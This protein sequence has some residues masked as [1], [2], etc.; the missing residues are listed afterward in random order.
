MAYRMACMSG[1]TNEAEDKITQ[2]LVTTIV[3]G[4]EAT[5]QYLT[6]QCNNINNYNRKTISFRQ[7][8]QSP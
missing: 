4:D 5:T 3:M 7:P 6:H 8:H 2:V 1:S